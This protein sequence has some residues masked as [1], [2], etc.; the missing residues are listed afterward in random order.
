MK[1][2]SKLLYTCVLTLSLVVAA[3]L[4]LV[5]LL[6]P[7]PVALQ[8]PETGTAIANFQNS[9]RDLGDFKTLEE[10]ARVLGPPTKIV[11]SAAEVDRALGAPT[12]IPTSAAERGDK[13][14]VWKGQ[15]LEGKRICNREIAVHILPN[16]EL[17]GGHSGLHMVPTRLDKVKEFLTQ[18]LP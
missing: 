3:I 1:Y 5:R 12:Q 7:E 10:L 11:T 16:G 15:T 18:L 4:G 9:E 13:A 17:E 2:R 6:V 14:V 8:S